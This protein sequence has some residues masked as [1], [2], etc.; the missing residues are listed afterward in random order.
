MNID[1]NSL[2][3][4]IDKRLKELDEEDATV[5]KDEVL[6]EFKIE[7]ESIKEQIQK[8]YEE[9]LYE[10]NNMIGLEEVKSE[11]KKL[12]NYL[13][14]IK[15]TSNKIKI[16]SINLN[17]VFRGNPGTGKTTV[18]RLVGKILCDLGFLKSRKFLETTPRDFIAE[19][20]G[21]TAI[22]AR[23]T[24]E[25]ASGGLILIDEAYT[26][27][28]S[29]YKNGDSFVPE[30]ITEI[31]KEME[32]LNTVF[33][34]SGYSNKMDDFININPGIKSRIGFDITFKDY[35]KE[36]LYM[37]LD[38]K[39]IKSGLKI[40][41]KAKE[42]AIEKIE[43]NMTKKNFGNGRMIDNLFDEIIRE[44]ASLNL[45]ETDYNKL[46][47]ITENS[48]KNIKVQTERSMNFE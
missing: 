17:M 37:M 41:K 7:T 4:K 29:M 28:Q 2:L 12:L 27:A 31:I 30:A 8:I 45:Y 47:L 48:I 33:I 35:T 43:A 15:K 22:K 20:I 13:I 5:Q 16:D 6:N 23:K 38:R 10:W 36:E 24:I 26:F 40:S 21:Q 25:K 11:I 1:V 14:F 9:Y 32:S 3:E 42:L 19:Y 44:H 39:I 34:F 18:A 46:L